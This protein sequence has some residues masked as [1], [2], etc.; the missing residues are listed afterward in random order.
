MPGPAARLNAARAIAAVDIDEK[1]IIDVEDTP[2]SPL[3]PA[4]TMTVLP[5]TSR[6]EFGPMNRPLS[7][8]GLPIPSGPQ[9]TFADADDADDRMRQRI[10]RCLC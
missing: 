9:Y 1:E 2:Q 3:P 7:V 6:M 4:P 5:Q 8:T 10:R